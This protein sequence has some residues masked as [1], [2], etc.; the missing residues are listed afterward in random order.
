M[1][2]SLMLSSSAAP[3][4][5]T[6]NTPISASAGATNNQAAFVPSDGIRAGRALVVTRM[7]SAPRGRGSRGLGGTLGHPAPLLEQ[8][9]HIAIECAECGVDGRASSNGLLAVLEHFRRDLLPFRYL[10]E[11]HHAVELVAKRACITIVRQRGVVPGAA[12]RR[13]ITRELIELHLDVRPREILGQLERG[14]LVC[15][16]AEDDE[17]R[18]A[19]H[20]GSRAVGARERRSHP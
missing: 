15:R 8:V 12:R 3:T 14:V 1:S 11:W 19:S 13:Q 18:A 6:K 4:G 7:S 5:S 2:K 20:G 16:A 17:A 9:V 10:R